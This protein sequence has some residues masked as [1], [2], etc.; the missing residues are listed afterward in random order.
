MYIGH[1][2]TIR[3]KLNY[4]TQEETE[5]IEGVVVDVN[6]DH[7]GSLNSLYVMSV[8]NNGMGYIHSAPLSDIIFHDGKKVLNDI[9]N[10][11]DQMI[12]QTLGMMLS[13]GR[14]LEV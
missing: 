12:N 1:K 13:G 4:S 9:K 8:K 10:P 5:E 11:Y 7:H 6:R 2:V 3:S 14:A